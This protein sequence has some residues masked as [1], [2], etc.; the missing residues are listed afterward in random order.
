MEKILTIIVP[1]YNS[2]EYLERCVDSLL[3]GGKRVEIIL[4]DDG[5]ADATAK[6]GQSTTPWQSPA[7]S[8]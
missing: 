7:G 3:G 6:A 8:T 5:S 1:C 4:V 2:A